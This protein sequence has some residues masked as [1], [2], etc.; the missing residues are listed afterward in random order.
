MIPF[1]SRRGRLV[2]SI[3]GGV[4]GGGM[5]TLAIMR[6]DAQDG[7]A[8]E[9]PAATKTTMKDAEVGK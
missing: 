2:R 7:T 6:A 5:A 9:G 1:Q 3:L 4:I 8:H